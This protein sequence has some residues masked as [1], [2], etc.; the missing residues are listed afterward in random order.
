MSMKRIAFAI[1]ILTFMTGALFAQAPARGVAINLPI[2][3]RLTGA[4][5]TLFRTAVDISNNSDAD[6]RVDFYLDGQDLGTGAA[7]IANGSISGS[8]DIGAFAQ[9]QPMRGR[10]NAHFDD[11]VDALARAGTISTNAFLGSVLFIFDGRTKSGEC[12]VTSRFY[13]AF[14][15]GNVGVALKGREITTNEP[16][17]LVATVLDTRGNNAGAPE[18]YPNL[19]I[20]NVGVAAGGADEPADSVDVEI[21]AVSNATG[22]AIGKTLTIADVPPGRTVVIS[23]VLGALGIP[24]SVE[25]TI[26]VFARVRSGNGA[27][28]GVISQVDVITR[29]GAVFD[30]SRADF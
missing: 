11:F 25:R 29:D 2:V 23:D 15:G 30:M 4:G 14:A 8:G 27:I 16:Q 21:S 6:V 26:L 20:N 7:I 13:N 17:R 18:I 12:A 24:T 5:N 10:S 9:G 1:S 22:Q 19:F 3:G 28:Q